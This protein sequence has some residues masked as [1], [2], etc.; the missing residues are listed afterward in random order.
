MIEMRAAGF[1]NYGPAEVLHVRLM[2]MPVNTRQQ[3]LIRVHAVG[4]QPGRDPGPSR[5]ATPGDRPHFPA[6]TGID[7]AGE[8]AQV[9]FEVTG[10]TAGEYGACWAVRR[11]AWPSTS[12]STLDR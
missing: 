4:T 9:G 5:K 7:F 6:M 12:P 11:V 1:D 10:V 2:P 3:V 8:V